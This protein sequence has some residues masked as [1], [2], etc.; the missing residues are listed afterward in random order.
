M[1]VYIGMVTDLSR[2][3]GGGAAKFEVLTGGPTRTELRTF[4]WEVLI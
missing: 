2:E 4:R 3:P 1:P